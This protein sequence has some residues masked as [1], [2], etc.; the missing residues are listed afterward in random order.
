MAK[1]I[2][3]AT[4]KVIAPVNPKALPEGT[5]LYWNGWMK[6]T[7]LRERP[8]IWEFLATEAA[9]RT[10]IFSVADVTRVGV[11]TVGD[12][13]FK[14]EPTT[15]ELIAALRSLG[16]TLLSPGSIW[17]A[18][19]QIDQYSQSGHFWLFT[20]IVSDPPRDPKRDERDPD[21]ELPQRLAFCVSK[22]VS[23]EGSVE[24]RVSAALLK[25]GDRWSTRTV[26]LQGLS[27]VG[28][29]PVNL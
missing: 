19:A 14:D 20:T 15:E 22:K 2:N 28:A 10:A 8:F 23:Q 6:K 21:P 27:D 12:L 13:G 17:P 9:L 5:P 18:L 26:L 7:V 4:T 29:P 25:R 11:G 1:L 24:Y 3:G 16:H